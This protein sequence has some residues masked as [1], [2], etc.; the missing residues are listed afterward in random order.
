MASRSTNSCKVEE[1]ETEEIE[2]SSLTVQDPSSQ[3][4]DYDFVE[5]PD[6]DYFCPVSLE[7]LTQP[8]QTDCCGHHVSQQAVNRITRDKKPCPMCKEDDFATHVDKFFKR[9]VR[10]LKVYCPYKKSWC[11]WTGELGD[12]DQHTTT[13]PKRPW[14]CPYCELQSTYDI[15]PTDHTPQCDYQP[16]PCPNHCEVV[17]TIPRC[18]AE[19]HLLICPLQLVDCE[20]ASAGCDVRVPRKDMA[21]HMTESAQQ[22]LM[23][24]TLLNLRLTKDLYQKIE[25]KDKQ[26]AE[27]KEEMNTKI[28]KLTQNINTKHQEN[29]QLAMKLSTRSCHFSTLTEFTKQQAKSCEGNW[30]SKSFYNYP[31]GYKFR[32]NIKTNGCVSAEGTHFSAFLVLY[33]G[34][35][36]EQLPWPVKVEVTL[37]MLNQKKDNNHYSV[38]QIIMYKESVGDNI[39]SDITSIDSDIIAGLD[40]DFEDGLDDLNFYLGGARSPPNFGNSYDLHDLFHIQSDDEDNQDN[41]VDDEKYVAASAQ[42]DKED[43][44]S[45]EENDD[46][47][48]EGDH[49]SIGKYKFFLLA[50]LE[51]NHYLKNDE[52]KFRLWLKMIS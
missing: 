1:P 2:A 29:M 49:K 36:D 32:L 18:H 41:N 24:A 19:K 31:G 38:T 40:D 15:G 28:D 35:Y 26:I 47:Y 7:L 17:G 52:L 10:Q 48:Y 45:N 3:Q 13:C 20:F 23:T 22:H 44:D 9:K 50:K 5:Q 27:L 12:L 37:D 21:G 42:D 51:E 4:P 6:Q 34:A 46:D 43:V 8:H 25:E 16:M 14:K 33:K 30:Y 39:D 11:K